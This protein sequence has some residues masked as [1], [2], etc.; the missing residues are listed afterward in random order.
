[1]AAD[2]LHKQ[3]QSKLDQTAPAPASAAASHE[4][5]QGRIL[6]AI[7]DFEPDRLDGEIRRALLLGPSMDVYEQV[8]VPVMQ[9]LGERWTVDDPLS[10]AQEHLVTEVMRSALQDL[11][12][13]SRPAQPVA[14]AILA[15]ISGELHVLP[16]YAIAFRLARA[17]IRTVILGARTPPAAIQIAVERLD[18]EFVALSSTLSVDPDRAALVFRAYGDACGSTPWFV[19]GA[20]VTSVDSAIK[21]AGGRIAG[22]AGSFDA[23]VREVVRRS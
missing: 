19:G 15:C 16:L 23:Q 18:P 22:S 6:K 20:G 8:I 11:H 17:N 5:I 9:A 12:R 21:D 4:I 7:D 14:T 3:D 13:L 1:L 2:Q 10:T